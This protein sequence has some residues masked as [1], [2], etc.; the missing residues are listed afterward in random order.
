MGKKYHENNAR[1]RRQIRRKRK[2]GQG[3]RKDK[4]QKDRART[5]FHKIMGNLEKK[6]CRQ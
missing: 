6:K 2:K 1:A 5:M 3:K 4:G